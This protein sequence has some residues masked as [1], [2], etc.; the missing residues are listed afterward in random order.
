MCGKRYNYERL[1][2][3]RYCGNTS[4]VTAM[5]CHLLLK[6]KA[7]VHALQLCDYFFKIFRKLCHDHHRMAVPGMGEAQNTSMQALTLLAKLFFLVTVDRVAQNGVP[8]IGHMDTDL[9]G[10]AGLQLAADVGLPP[11]PLHPFPMGDG[12]AG[13]ALGN[14]HFL[15]VGG[16]TAN[17]RVHR[18]GILLQVAADNGLVGPGHGV[19]F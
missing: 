5:P 3:N 13:V 4:P 17:G 10:A 12:I 7:L 9:V 2:A 11:I 16:V 1:Y 14:T 19:V 8:H 6:E 15:A 18:A